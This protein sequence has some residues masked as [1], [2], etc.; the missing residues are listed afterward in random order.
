MWVAMG[1]ACHTRPNAVLNTLKYALAWRSAAWWQKTKARTV[2]ID[3]N[4]HT[5]WKHNFGWHNR[6]C[7][8]DQIASGC[9]GKE[10]WSIK[11][12]GC[13]TEGYKRDFVTFSLSS[14]EH[15][16]IHRPK[17]GESVKTNKERK[18]PRIL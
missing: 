5:R 6:G 1:W 18:E 15:P 3:P 16:V 7:V 17:I 10:D 4:N 9:S 11:R 2:K 12:K 14:A 13:Q 8:W